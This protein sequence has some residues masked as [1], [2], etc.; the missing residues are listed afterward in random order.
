MVSNIYIYTSYIPN[1]FYIDSLLD[2]T[3][4]SDTIHL[5][6]CRPALSEDDT[7]VE[8]LQSTKDGSNG[9]CNQDTLKANRNGAGHHKLNN[10]NGNGKANNRPKVATILRNPSMRD[11]EVLCE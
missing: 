1:Y 10:G 9:S 7:I 6:K 4:N 2:A 3:I 5:S 11:R 8:E